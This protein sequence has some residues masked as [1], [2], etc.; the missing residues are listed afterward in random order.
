MNI[1]VRACS[2]RSCQNHVNNVVSEV[3]YRMLNSEVTKGP[4]QKVAL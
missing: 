4:F 1:K 2:K 3:L